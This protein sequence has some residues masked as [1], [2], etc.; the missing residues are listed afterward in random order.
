MFYLLKMEA[1]KNSVA[2][3]GKVRF[4]A[5]ADNPMARGRPWLLSPRTEQNVLN[6]L[7]A[8]YDSYLLNFMSNA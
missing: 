8:G 4:S 3:H 7:G 5:L 2:F 6:T 1:N